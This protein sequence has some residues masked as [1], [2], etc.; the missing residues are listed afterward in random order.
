MAGKGTNVQLQPSMLLELERRG[1]R[2]A[3]GGTT[4]SRSAVLRR[5]LDTWRAL[6]DDADPR[7]QLEPRIYQ[8]ALAL[9]PCGWL[10]TPFEIRFLPEVLAREAAFPSVLE[11]AGLAADPFLA[12]IAGLPYPQKAALVDHAIQLHAPAASAGEAGE[13]AAR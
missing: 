10:L 7:R 3:R 8:A 2:S 5:A 13:A 1:A 11:Q 4:F 6:L 12:A 9:L